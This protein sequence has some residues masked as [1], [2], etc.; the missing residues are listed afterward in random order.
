M[1]KLTLPLILLAG[2]LTGCATAPAPNATPH[3][4]EGECKRASMIYK[5][6][7]SRIESIIDSCL[8]GGRCPNSADLDYLIAITKNYA[9]CLELGYIPPHGLFQHN[10][11]KNQ[12][13]ISKVKRLKAKY[14]L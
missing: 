8:A 11:R 3:T 10:N 5:D 6:G 1:K 14:E 4:I 12:I 7:S 13:L 9:D 2:A